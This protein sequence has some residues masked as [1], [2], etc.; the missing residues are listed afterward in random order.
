[1]GQRLVRVNELLKREI[2]LV[3]HTA[4]QAEAVDITILAVDTAPNLRRAKV[5]FA[6]HGDG[7]GRAAAEH[8]LARRQEAIRR[9]VGSKVRLKYLPALEFIYD[10]G[11]DHGERINNLLDELGLEGEPSREWTPEDLK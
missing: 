8:F 6:T 11:S 7:R 1:M 4:Y 5:F 9:E 3:L 10:T 2:S